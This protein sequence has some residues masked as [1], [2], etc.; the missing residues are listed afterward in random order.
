[1]SA[2]PLELGGPEI[3]DAPS[4]MARAGGENFPVAAHV[5]SRRHRRHLLSV[6]G[7]ARLAD[8]LGDELAGD[9][10]AALDWLER[11]LDRAYAGQARHPLLLSL[12]GTLAECPLPRAPFVR[13]IDANR[14]DQRVTRYE[15]WE[16]LRSYCELSANPVGELVLCVFA[17]ATPERIALSNQ[18][19]TALQLVEHLQ[20]LGEDMR[21]GRVYLPAEDLVRFGCSVEQLAVLVC[22]GDPDL[23]L[24]GAPSSSPSPH[25]DCE[26]SAA[27]LREVVSFETS[28]AREL[29]TG[30]VPLLRG[31]G[32]RPRLALAAFVAGGRAALEQIE[33]ASFDVLGGATRASRPRRV[34][35]LLRLLAESRG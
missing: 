22:K 9:R 23:D 4:V 31:V 14:L 16:Q 6:Y 1:M 26:R 30:G 17:L 21:R 25:G 8:D 33:H 18:V 27:R 7:F 29:L 3:P 28:R 2:A 5:L 11:E 32:G 15:T 20:D 10:L 35:A 13:L 24:R 19:C 12:Q 34:G